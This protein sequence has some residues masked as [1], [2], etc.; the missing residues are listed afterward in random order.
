VG[1]AEGF[2][3]GFDVGLEEGRAVGLDDGLAVGFELGLA[4]G[5]TD[6]LAVGRVVGFA[7]GFELGFLVG[8]FVGL[9]VNKGSAGGL[10]VFLGVTPGLWR[11]SLALRMKRSL[12]LCST[13]RS[14]AACIGPKRPAQMAVVNTNMALM[15]FDLLILS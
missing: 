4:V 5:F 7:V 15:D 11:S 9:N 3:E 1:L 6:G 10:V 14:F 12:V 8:L 2:A 13:S